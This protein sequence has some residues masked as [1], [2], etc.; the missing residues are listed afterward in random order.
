MIFSVR[1][2]QESKPLYISFIDL[3]KSTLWG[4]SQHN[5]NVFK[6]FKVLNGVKQGTITNTL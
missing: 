6:L 2:L 4:T 3:T 1:Q 5:G